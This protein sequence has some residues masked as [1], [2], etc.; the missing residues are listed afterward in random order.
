M[1]FKRIEWIFLVVFIGINIF[2]GIEILQTPTLLSGAHSTSGTPTDLTTEIKADNISIPKVNDLQGEGYYLASKV[3]NSWFNK[4]KDQLEDNSN[5]DLTTSS[6]D[7]AVSATIKRPISIS[8]DA[9][10][11]TK[12]VENFKN[13]PK[14]VYQGKKYTYVPHLSGRGEYV[15][16]QKASM[17]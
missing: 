16:A 12:Q 10:K 14:Y 7:S 11:A 9:K 13:N 8:K 4:A 3:D 2:L 15:F 5:L 1:D 6:E 17:D